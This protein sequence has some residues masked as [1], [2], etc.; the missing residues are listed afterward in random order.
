ME[1]Q[2][3]HAVRY[4]H[5]GGT[6]VLYVAELEKP[7]PKAGEVLVRVK[8]AGINPGEASIREGKLQK[9]F[10]STFPSGQGTDFAGIVEQAGNGASKFKQGDEVIGFSNNRNSQA[11]Y[12]AVPEDQL[13]IK[14]KDISWEEA[15]GLFVVGT[16]AYA[17]VEAVGLKTGDTVIISGAAGGVG[18]IAVQLAKNLG[19]NVI[20]LAGEPGHQWLKEHGITPV[21]YEGDRQQALAKALGGKKA[22]AFIDTS[23]DGYVEMAVR[24]GIRS[25]RIDTIIDF[26]AAQRY[27]VKTD[28][29]S[30]AG[31]AE[32]L[33]KVADMVDKGDVEIPIA[34]TY[35]LNRVKQ[36]YKELEKHHTHGKIV[37]VASAN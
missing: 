3:N 5:F 37:L 1:N 20:G 17:A 18:S 32:V 31:N 12:I 28:G 27:R 35:P 13:V 16:T 7:S 33:G 30:K 14:P 19:A 21:S 26:E 11:E 29:N 10:P 6:D 23:G 15:G 4:D 2:K 8:T 36:A 25:D 34:K 9:M 24:M 22:D